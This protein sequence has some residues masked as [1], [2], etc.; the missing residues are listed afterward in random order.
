MNSIFVFNTTNFEFLK[1]PTLEACLA[2][3][4]DAPYWRIQDRVCW[5][6]GFPQFIIHN[7]YLVEWSPEKYDDYLHIVNPK[8][9]LYKMSHYS[10]S[11]LKK[12]ANQ[13]NVVDTGTRS[14]LY[15]R[16]VEALTLNL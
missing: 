14:E 1:E 3:I 10:A 7:N 12:M 11:E 16:I 4:G 13:L 15:A 6:Y 2:R 5:R 8:K 9:P